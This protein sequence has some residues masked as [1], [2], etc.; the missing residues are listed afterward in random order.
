MNPVKVSV[1]IP[2][3]NTAKYLTEAINS[4]Q[5]Q[6][7]Q[8]IEIIA[9][10]DGS[11]DESFQILVELSKT[12]DRIKVISF[13]KNV[14]VS[15]CRN[16]GMERA[17]GEFLY[18]FDSDDILN[19]DCLELCY[20]KMSNE[21]F[22]FLIFDGISFYQ[23]GIK[24]GFNPNYERTQYL[25]KNLYSGK[26]ILKELN[27]HNGYSCS[28]CLCFIRKSYL[29]SIGLKFYPEVL[30]EDILFTII[31]YLSSQKVSF[32]NRSLFKRRIRP[33]STMTSSISQKNIDYR[34][35]ICKE[36]IKYKDEF[37]DS[38]SKQLLNLQVRNV[39]KYLIKNLLHSHQIILFLS[40]LR[41][42]FNLYIKG[43]S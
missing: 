2:V 24:T 35:I 7:L 1:I 25:S 28:V 13:D 38:D 11:E 33:N 15:I 37:T 18:F 10:N 39:L 17:K 6:S 5:H 42:V 8:D 20:Q 26:E 12:D 29:D 9:I 14:G 30:Y 21:T 27:K 19:Y 16:S 32:I 31:L 4:I 36:I 23:E 40:N 3:F 34:L 41:P 43:L 22:D